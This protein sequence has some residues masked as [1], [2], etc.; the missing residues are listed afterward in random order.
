[1]RRVI[2]LGRVAISLAAVAAVTVMY[3]QFLPVNPTTVALTYLAA[4]LLIASFWGI[5]EATAASLTAVLCFNFFFLP[6]IGTLTIAD[7]QNWVAL[8][9]F[10]ITAVVTSQL[11]GR[12][13]RR[14]LEAAERQ[15]DLEHLYALSRSLLLSETGLSLPAGIAQRI[16]ETFEL[17]AVALFDQQTDAIAQGGITELRHIE[18]RLRDVARSAVAVH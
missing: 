13:Q 7:P 16:A 5:G 18:P 11:S 17:P 14:N 9:A 2:V 1:M 8:L 4:I 12:A 10:L 15:R 3:S 6:P